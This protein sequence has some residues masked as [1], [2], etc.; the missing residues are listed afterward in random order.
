MCSFRKVRAHSQ[1]MTVAARRWRRGRPWDSDHSVSPH[2]AILEPAEH[3]LDAVASLVPVLVVLDGFLT[4][5]STGDKCAY[6]FVF[7]RL[8]E[9]VGI[10][11]ADPE[12]PVDVRQ[13]LSHARAPIGLP[14]IPSNGSHHQTGG[15]NTG[16]GRDLRGH[17]AGRM[18]MRSVSPSCRS[19]GRMAR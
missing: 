6:P 2:A 17:S 14:S 1:Y 12:Q 13:L 10:I 19:S 7:K 3:D 4:L 15:S 16:K 18:N 5:F 9:P 8:S 11:S